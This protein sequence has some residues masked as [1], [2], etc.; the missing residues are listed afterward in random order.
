MMIVIRG[1]ACVWCIGVGQGRL[2]RVYG[3]SGGGML[4]R[5]RA[6]VIELRA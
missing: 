1:R 6:L 3:V 4:E 2:G 5:G